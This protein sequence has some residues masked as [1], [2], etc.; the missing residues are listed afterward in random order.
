MPAAGAAWQ[1]A[2]GS[3]PA[4]FQAPKNEPLCNC[5]KKYALKNKTLSDLTL[6]FK[7]Q[8]NV[9]TCSNRLLSLPT[10]S[11]VNNKLVKLLSL[12]DEETC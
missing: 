2:D 7:Q 3:N 1:K 5:T 9:T 8:P 11:I 6:V 4:V 10:Y 12:T